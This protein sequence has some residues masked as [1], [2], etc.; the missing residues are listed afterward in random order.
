MR[1]S[2]SPSISKKDRPNP[3]SKNQPER[4]RCCLIFA[5]REQRQPQRMVSSGGYLQALHRH[6]D[7]PMVNNEH[8]ALLKQGVAAWNAWRHE[9]RTI[10]P[11][12]SGADLTR[13]DLSGAYLLGADLSR[14]ILS[15]ANLSKANLTKANLSGAILS[16]TD[17]RGANLSDADLR[18]ANLSEANLRRANLSKANLRGA[19][20]V[21][22]NFWSAN[23]RKA[24]LSRQ[25]GLVRG[26]RE[27]IS[28]TCPNSQP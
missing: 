20:L 25:R 7:A 21:E 17:L 18:G 19:D 2:F 28:T 13:A 15:G 5:S 8:V 4:A 22:A 27:E 1:A 3:T 26:L 6:R 14:A 23:L 9:N 11:N 24:D 16:E 12:L 10:S